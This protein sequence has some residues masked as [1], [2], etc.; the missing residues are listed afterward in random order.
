M[1]IHINS[2]VVDV[3]PCVVSIVAGKDPCSSVSSVRDII[4][5][6]TVRSLL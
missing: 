2:L 5:K 1:V 3:L 4:L 6:A